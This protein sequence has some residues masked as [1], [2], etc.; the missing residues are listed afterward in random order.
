LCPTWPSVYPSELDSIRRRIDDELTKALHNTVPQAMVATASKHRRLVAVGAD[1][2]APCPLSDNRIYGA[3]LH[4]CLRVSISKV[5]CSQTLA[6]LGTLTAAAYGLS[7]I[8]ARCHHRNGLPGGGASERWAT[9]TVGS[10]SK[11]YD[12]H[13]TDAD[14]HPCDGTSLKSSTP[15]V[16]VVQVGS[17]AT[18]MMRTRTRLTRCR[19]TAWRTVASRP[20][21]PPPP[22]PPPSPPPPSRR[23]APATTTTTR[24][25]T[26][27]TSTATATKRNKSRNSRRAPQ[28]A[29]AAMGVVSAGARRGAAGGAGAMEEEGV[30]AA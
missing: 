1:A 29:A 22:P 14:G 4:F 23:R 30:V 2:D 15:G 12:R 28:G 20:P 17:W 16:C 3:S 5:I 24:T 6:R 21:P 19:A 7:F 8:W 25:T 10:T 18:R 26:T 13:R 11:G 9:S 27:A